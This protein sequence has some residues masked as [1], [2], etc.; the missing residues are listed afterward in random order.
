MTR[1]DDYLSTVEAPKRLALERIR[2]LAKTIVPGAEDAIVYGMPTLTYQGKPLL[3][4]AAHKNHLGLYPYSGEVIEML[5]D[6][7]QG[8]GMS[9]GAIRLPL[10]KPI[11]EKLIARVIACRLELLADST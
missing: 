1:I 6:E 8:Y 10:D 9:K 11:P 5:R 3:G 4:F 2:T 7:L